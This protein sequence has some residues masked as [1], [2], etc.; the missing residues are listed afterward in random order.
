MV[1]TINHLAHVMG[2][3]T[4]AEYVENQELKLKLQSLGIDFG[5]GFGLA[6]PEPVE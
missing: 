1:S 2:L 6:V 3:K 5:Q 4:V